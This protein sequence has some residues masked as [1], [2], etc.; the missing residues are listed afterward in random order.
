MRSGLLLLTF[1]ASSILAVCPLPMETGPST[2]QPEAH[3]SYGPLIRIATYIDSKGHYK[4]I[5]P[6]PDSPN[7]ESALQGIINTALHEE[8]EPVEFE[9][10]R[11]PEGGRRGWLYVIVTGGKRCAKV[12]CIGWIASGTRIP[13]SGRSRISYGQ[14]YL[15]LYSSDPPGAPYKLVVAY[16]DLDEAVPSVFTNT[17]HIHIGKR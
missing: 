3:E 9:R 10:L 5:K 12:P 7:I 13:E 14:R 17:R 11:E 15:G 1:V 2:G 8:G 16:P 6:Y 4:P